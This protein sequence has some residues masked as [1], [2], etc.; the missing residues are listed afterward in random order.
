[1]DE[2][3]LESI[4]NLGFPIFMCVFLILKFDKTVNKLED[5]VNRLIEKLDLKD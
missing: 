5:T 1:M 4:A 2:W 3:I